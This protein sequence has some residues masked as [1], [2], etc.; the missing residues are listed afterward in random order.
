[1]EI[2]PKLSLNR[3]PKDIPNNS[4]VAAKNMVVDDTG[5]YFTNE[6]GFAVAFECP[7]NSEF[8]CG[9]IP[10]NKELVIFTYCTKDKVSRIYRYKDD[11]SYFEVN[12]GWNY[13][14]GKITGSYTYNYKG[15]LIIAVGEYDAID[16]YGATIQVPYKSWNLDST[17][18]SNHNQ[19]EE[20][21]KI[22]SSYNIAQG[23]LVCGV[24]TFFIRYAITDVDYTKWFQI[25]PEI[26]IIQ[27]KQKEAPS[28]NY[29]NGDTPV[30]LDTTNSNFE[31]L[32]INDNELSDKG[33]ELIVSND[34]DTFLKYQIGYIIK[35]NEE[36]LG[37][38]QNEYNIN[39]EHIIV[40]DNT[41]TEE[42]SVDD[43]L[44]SPNQ[45][46]NVQNIIN[47]NNRIYLSNY[48]E[49]KNQN[50]ESKD[51][52]NISLDSKVAK[53]AEQSTQHTNIKGYISYNGVTTGLDNISFNISN[54]DSSSDG[55]YVIKD[56]KS[57][58]INYIVKALRLY[59]S[60]GQ[61]IS[62]YSNQNIE[63]TEEG[64]K[65]WRSCVEDYSVC[66]F[67]GDKN[68]IEYVYIYTSNNKTVTNVT[69]VYI[70]NGEVYIT[71]SGTTIGTTTN[72]NVSIPLSEWNWNVK[73]HG[74]WYITKEEATNNGIVDTTA[75]NTPGYYTKF[76]GDDSPGF[77]NYPIGGWQ[78]KVNIDVTNIT[79]TFNTNNGIINKT[80]VPNQTYN[81]YVHFIRK[82]GS[83][84]NG[85]F[86]K[87]INSTALSNPIIYINV[88]IKNILND[89]IGYFLSYENVE[90]NVI[91]A[92]KLFN[93][94]G[95]QV[96]NTSFIYDN[97]S[98]Y[99]DKIGYT[100][101]N[102][103]TITGKTY[104]KSIVTTSNVNIKPAGVANNVYLLST[105]L[106]NYYKKTKTLYRLTDNYF[107]TDVHSSYNYLPGYYNREKIIVFAD[108]S[109]PT[110]ATQLK[111]IIFTATSSKVVNKD[112]TET[113][114]GLFV[115]SNYTYSTIPL[116]AYNIK[117]DYSKGA[118]S[119]VTS[120]GGTKG[121]FYNSVL[122]PDKLHDFLEIKGCYTAKPSKSFTNYSS[123][124]V[125]KF[126]KTIRRSNIISD[127]SLV[128]GFRLFESNQYKIIKENKGNITN[129]VGVGLYMLI[130]TEYSLF[131]FDRS[132]KLTQSSQLQIPDVF[133]IDYQ[134]VLPS[135]EGFG[136]LSNKDESIV[137]KNGYIWYDATN[138]IIFKYENGKASVLSSDINNFIKDLN[139]STVRFGEDLITNR[140]IVC[141][142]VTVNNVDYPIT[143]SYNFNT[144]TFIS[145]HDYS[146]TNCYRTYNVAYFLDNIK[147]KN[148][149][150]KFDESE[151]G[152]KNLRNKN[153]LYYPKYDLTDEAGESGA[154]P[155]P[156]T[157]ASDIDLI[158]TPVKVYY[159]GIGLKCNAALLNYQYLRLIIETIDGDLI[160]FGNTYPLPNTDFTTGYSPKVD[161]IKKSVTE[162]IKWR[163]PKFD[164]KINRVY[165]WLYDS[166]S[167]YNND[168]NAHPIK[169]IES[170]NL[171]DDIS[172]SLVINH[173]H[174]DKVT[175]GNDFTDSLTVKNDSNYNVIYLKDAIKYRIA[176]TKN[177][178]SNYDYNKLEIGDEVSLHRKDY[179]VEWKNY[180][181]NQIAN[182]HT[183][184][185]HHE[186]YKG[187]IY[188]SISRNGNNIEIINNIN[189]DSHSK[190][191]IELYR[192]NTL[193]GT[194][195]FVDVTESQKLIV[196]NMICNNIKVT[197]SS[198][199]FEAVSF[200]TNFNDNIGTINVID[201]H[202][203]SITLKPT[204]DDIEQIYYN[205]NGDN[206]TFDKTYNVDDN[207]EIK[208]ENNN[209]INAAIIIQ[210]GN[211]N[212]II[213]R[214][215]T[216]TYHYND[217]AINN[218][219]Y[220]TKGLTDQTNKAYIDVICNINPEQAKSLESIHYV[221]NSFA[222]KFNN[223]NPAEQLLNRRFSGN[224][225][226]LYSDETYTGAININDEGKT[227]QFD[228]YK[229]PTFQKGHWEFNYFRNDV[230]KVLE[231]GS[232][233]A[234]VYNPKT[235]AYERKLITDENIKD[236]YNK[237][238]DSKSLIYGRYIIARFIFNNDKRVKLE[239]VTFITNTY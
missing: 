131:V 17:I 124:Y 136:G 51:L 58:V 31:N 175:T 135:N 226:I 191:T 212:N 139:I 13:S 222:A 140:L 141:I 78:P 208:L 158:R 45:L 43:F 157:S 233:V 10:T 86:V 28:H 189:T 202:N 145:L 181:E 142:Y 2:V 32:L 48:E 74:T 98:I 14:G 73:I 148:R 219:N 137:S 183:E 92:T 47:Y 90:E 12:V 66:L 33:I 50:L 82:D 177:E 19:E 221:L 120:A 169:S 201:L 205:I 27:S 35:R 230:N 121:V 172:S 143:I 101:Y 36:V 130:H 165:G 218:N 53:S 223:M 23:N 109:N 44:K 55:K 232:F 40:A 4:I 24:Y 207:Q 203:G 164:F 215:I 239:G 11:G 106:G 166:E 113:T 182:I 9:V 235:N 184:E 129:I 116:D 150:Y 6:W 196:T 3:N 70:Q 200:Y 93:N 99:G 94:N 197:V 216:Y 41:F 170:N 108:D 234:I 54:V 39:N 146:F 147:D 117:Q 84:T 213:I 155:F 236:E 18:N 22:T 171:T 128:N 71:V 186:Y 67:R 173:N 152:Y 68:N 26:I 76:I 119:L 69:G 153:S 8:I 16:S 62:P 161:S 96:T 190:Y 210:Y 97:G 167:D 5:S 195:S 123:D 80:L 229:L 187:F 30:R 125:D 88:S 77:R 100:P 162:Y 168:V 59:N 102:T 95:S 160:E 192:D 114:Y 56:Y 85:Y 29:L 34:K 209:I 151:T 112:G 206:V 134:E 72:I 217:D 176:S 20:V 7:N 107:D 118:V 204:N 38:I 211:E 225:I 156:G 81:V 52:V 63:L 127:E 188:P 138:K 49:Y 185:I 126:D 144:N 79:E 75:Y 133:D 227:N 122:S 46:Y 83:Y 15:E 163:S 224:S 231:N 149:L 37:R 42:T 179:F 61:A 64:K 1:M 87:T 89:Y 25:T 91:Y 228:A 193:I 194:K 159:Y 238:D 132:P 178:L 105:N 180:Y 65:H 199:V 220:I 21:G 198:S 214:S 103:D 111:D 174:D 110:T 115:K 237:L 57:F 154:K 60:L 104:N